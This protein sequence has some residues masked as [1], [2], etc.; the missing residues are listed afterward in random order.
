[1]PDEALTRYTSLIHQLT[2]GH[3]WLRDNL[4]VQPKTSWV[5]DAFGHSSTVP[6]ILQ[7]SGIQHMVVHRIHQAVKN[8]LMRMQSLEFFWRPYWQLSA[9]DDI[10]C[11]VMPYESYSGMC[12]PDGEVCSQYDYLHL[13]SGRRRA[14]VVDDVNVHRLAT[15]LHQAYR[16][17]ANMYNLKTLL[18]FLGEDNAF[19]LPKSWDDVYTNFHKLITHINALPEFNMKIKF[20]TIRDYFKSIENHIYP[21][22]PAID[23]FHQSAVFPVVSGDFFPY[24]DKNNDYWTGFFSNRPWL[25]KFVRVTESLLHAA[26]TFSVLAHKKGSSQNDVFRDVFSRLMSARRET[27]LFQHHD[28]ITGTSF[29][30]VIRDLEKRLLVAYKHALNALK[31]SLTYRISGDSG[32]A[33]ALQSTI[34]TP[35]ATVPLQPR[36]LNAYLGTLDLI[37]INQLFKSRTQVVSVMVTKPFVRLKD[38]DGNVVACQISQQSRRGFL[39]SFPVSMEPFEIKTI[40]LEVLEET[41]ETKDAYFRY[42]DP[43]PDIVK[44]ENMHVSVFIDSTSGSLVKICEK[45]GRQQ[46]SAINSKFMQYRSHSSGPYVFSA[47]GNAIEIPQLLLVPEIKV[48]RGPVI[49]EVEVNYDS[50]FVQTFT[51]YNVPGPWG[52][53]L[54]VSNRIKLPEQK[55]M[56]NTEIILRFKT[57]VNNDGI[58]F[59][60]QN[61]LQL[62][63]RQNDKTRSAEKN[64]YPMT[65]LA[66]LED[67]VKR[68]TLHSAQSLGVASLDNGWL[69]VMLDRVMDHG[70]GKGLDMG[71][72]ERFLTLTEFVIHMEYKSS[73]RVTFE[74]RYTYPSVSSLILNEQLQNNI[75]TLFKYQG[76]PYIKPP[77]VRRSIPCDVSVASLRTLVNNGLE[78]IGTSLILHRSGLHCAFPAKDLVCNTNGTFTVKQFL[79]V[80]GMDHSNTVIEETSLTHSRSIQTLSLCDNILPTKNELRTLLIKQRGL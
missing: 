67:K 77:S 69:E 19:N 57:D 51:L 60:D 30:H 41:E 70:D 78:P 4:G 23:G 11:N 34:D 72:K 62:I 47:A 3:Q 5:N 14:V 13:T 38:S 55:E 22:F 40:T 56:N 36:V 10:L 8:T 18:L 27:N 74:P 7:K 6:Y 71:I 76:L 75:I 63:G 50:G 12:G 39:V 49:S 53:G 44:I 33:Q 20:G 21:P 1:M 52:Q 42:F 59:T 80:L 25:K 54:H 31:V 35:S 29:P 65:T 58:F 45:F 28:A 73:T 43:E 2:D 37:I 61:G 66:I 68:F 9:E 24:S 79:T 17:T 15:Q 48:L 64:Y 16:F 46:C 26:E 32:S